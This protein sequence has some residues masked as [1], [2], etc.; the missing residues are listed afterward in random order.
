MNCPC[1]TAKDFKTCCEKFITGEATPAHPEEVMRSR[2][3]AFATKN[4]PYLKESLDPQNR[5]EFNAAATQQWADGADFTRLEIVRSEENGNKGIV[6][7]KAH[8]TVKPI[9]ENPA[10]EHVHHETGTFRKNQGRWF[11][12]TGKIHE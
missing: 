3:S 7:F 5:H 10:A 4:I 6:E 2:Y 8:F 9:G 12:K 1:G 11:Y